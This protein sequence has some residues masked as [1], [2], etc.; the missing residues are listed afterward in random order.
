MHA[1]YG[2]SISYHSKVRALKTDRHRR[3]DRWIDTQIGQKQY[4]PHLSLWGIKIWK[5]V[6]AYILF[7][8]LENDNRKRCRVVTVAVG[9]WVFGSV[10]VLQMV[11]KG[12]W[13]PNPVG[14]SDMTDEN[15]FGPAENISF[16]DRMSGNVFSDNELKNA[17]N[18]STLKIQSAK[19][20]SV[21]VSF[22][23]PG[24]KPSE[25][26]SFY[27][28]YMIDSIVWRVRCLKRVSELVS[29]SLPV[30]CHERFKDPDK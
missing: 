2:F 19:S 26:S 25:Q 28:M 17:R 3:T 29:F 5:L 6:C 11:I 23:I 8:H 13:N 15:C 7:H 14:P 27:L 24:N 21:A 30:T 16:P 1:K 22:S 9:I 10:P 18:A 4:G 20:C 12:Q